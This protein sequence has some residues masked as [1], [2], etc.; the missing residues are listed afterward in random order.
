VAGVDGPRLDLAMGGDGADD[1]VDR[2]A[3]NEALLPR[4]FA[5]ALFL[6]VDEVADP[7]DEG[8]PTEDELAGDTVHEIVLDPARGDERA[9][10]LAGI[11]TIE[12]VEG[13]EQL[14]D[15]EPLGG[16]LEAGRRAVAGPLVA[17]GGLAR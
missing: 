12:A 3:A 1:G 10:G 14:V 16:F 6:L 8:F 17:A 5:V 7:G 2:R 13:V 9:V 4:V 15:G 11:V